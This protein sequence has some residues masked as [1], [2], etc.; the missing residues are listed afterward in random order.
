VAHGVRDAVPIAG[1][2]IANQTM[3]QTSKDVERCWKI[4]SLVIDKAG[5]T[6]EP[7]GSNPVGQLILTLDGHFSNIQM[8]P[9]LASA[10]NLR[11]TRGVVGTIIAYFGTY[12]MQGREATVKT[13]GSTRGDWQNKTQKRTIESVSPESVWVD[14]PTPELTA[15][16]IYN[17]CRG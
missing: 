9:D 3:A 10:A 14:R 13:E 4:R 15:R 8:R 16:V 7:Y 6:I 1:L 17:R 11:P 5:K 12:Q 2:L